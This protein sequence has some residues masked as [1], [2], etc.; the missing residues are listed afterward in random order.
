VPGCL[1]AP[2]RRG[3]RAPRIGR[4]LA[5]DAIAAVTSSSIS[6]GLRMAADPVTIG[7]MMAPRQTFKPRRSSR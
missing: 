3:L 4:R 6:I 5:G 7:R 2:V 1:A